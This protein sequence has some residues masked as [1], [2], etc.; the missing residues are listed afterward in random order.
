MTSA[1]AFG[2]AALALIALTS[3][4]TACSPADDH[5]TASALQHIHGL[6]VVPQTGELVVATHGGLYLLDRL[7]KDADLSGP[8]AGNDF[9]AMGFTI[10]GGAFYASGHPGAHSPDHFGAGNLGLIRSDDRGATWQNVAFPGEADFHDLSVS[11]VD[12][13]RIYVNAFGVLHRSDDAGRTWREGV[14]IDAWDILVAP[15]LPDTVYATSSGGLLV[16]TD[17]GATFR[18][19]P[20]APRMGLIAAFADGRLV[21][22]GVDGRIVY[23]GAD[24]EWTTGPE[25]RGTSGALTTTPDDGIVLADQRGVLLSTD[26]RSW[27]RLFAPPEH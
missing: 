1:P 20:G 2:R 4:L 10:A 15:G 19:V 9:D 18:P 12:P 8:I 5:A 11:D 3:L 17:A 16:S 6:A 27:E 13:R 26:L 24:G 7:D 22:T 21:G 14:G 23:Q 25:Y